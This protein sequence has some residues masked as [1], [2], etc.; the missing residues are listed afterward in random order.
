MSV[1]II[2]QATARHHSPYSAYMN[3]LG[4]PRRPAPERG[5][6]G[7]DCCWKACFFHGQKLCKKKCDMVICKVGQSDFQ[8]NFKLELTLFLNFRSKRGYG[9]TKSPGRQDFCAKISDNAPPKELPGHCAEKCL[10]RVHFRSTAQGPIPI[11]DIKR[12]P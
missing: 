12:A 4:R 8:T 3:Y 11:A 9:D 5:G 6:V 2:C 7:A 10:G 1:L